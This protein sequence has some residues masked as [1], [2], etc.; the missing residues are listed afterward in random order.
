MV[1]SVNAL[2]DGPRTLPPFKAGLSLSAP[3]SAASATSA[4]PSVI[5]IPS[6]EQSSLAAPI[7][8]GEV[9]GLALLAILTVLLFCWTRYRRPNNT[10]IVSD[11]EI[12]DEK[13]FEA[14][15]QSFPQPRPQL[16]T[17]KPSP[18]ESWQKRRRRGEAAQQMGVIQ[19]E[20]RQLRQ[21]AE[22]RRLARRNTSKSPDRTDAQILA[23]LRGLGAQIDGLERQI[24][25]MGGTRER[26]AP[27]QYTSRRPW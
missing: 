3:G 5:Y 9:G 26:E 4:S 27:P 8:A 21:Q 10:G 7:A 13:E 6:P 23:T 25:A 2:E 19:Q 17:T 24:Q 16:P 12:G 15:A 20:I 1:F 14:A 18:A 11:S 22:A